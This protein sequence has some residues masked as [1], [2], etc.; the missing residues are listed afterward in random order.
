M[1]LTGKPFSYAQIAINVR[2]FC[3]RGGIR[4]ISAQPCYQLIRVPG[5]EVRYLAQCISCFLSPE[6]EHPL[7]QNPVGK[8]RKQYARSIH[9][10]IQRV[11]NTRQ[12]IDAEIL[13]QLG[14]GTKR[15]YCPRLDIPVPEQPIILL[16][17]NQ[18]QVECKRDRQI[19]KIKAKEALYGFTRPVRT[20]NEKAGNQEYSKDYYRLFTVHTTKVRPPQGH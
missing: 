11:K 3:V 9:H 2:S 15:K 6:T 17:Q 10:E 4:G 8:G 20:N 5:F 19:R 18:Q 7:E 16:H 13:E 12:G 1:V 14:K